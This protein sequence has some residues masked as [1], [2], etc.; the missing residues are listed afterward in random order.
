M[1][2]QPFDANQKGVPPE[3]RPMILPH[4]SAL[5]ANRPGVAVPKGIPGMVSDVGGRSCDPEGVSRS[6]HDPVDGT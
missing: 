1:E 4:E 6:A 5:P 3:R 2:S